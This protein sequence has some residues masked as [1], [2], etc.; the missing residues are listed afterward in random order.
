MPSAF[1]LARNVSAGKIRGLKTS[2]LLT[3]PKWSNV[4]A[5]AVLL[6]LATV[7]VY[8][9]ILLAY[10]AN[11][12]TLTVGYAPVQ[13]VPYSHAMH[14]GKLGMDCRY[15]HTTV[16]RAAFAALPP[17]DVCMNCHKAILP[18]SPKLGLVQESYVEGTPVP[19]VKVHLMAD[20]VYF[21]HSAH[22]NVGV[23]CIECHG[24][25]Q[26]METV[27]IVKPL[28]MAWCLECHRDPRPFLRPRDQ[29]TN[30]DWTPLGADDPRVR[31]DLGKRLMENYHVNPSTDCVTCHR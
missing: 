28:N 25:I 10:G 27:E 31:A 2:T 21:N 15:C 4:A 14:V 3:F 6:G 26:Q 12:T 8:L 11:P 20:Y 22:V 1:P 17:T 30:M 29:V 16:E 24:P 5:A 23:G 9:G 18:D 7:P 19:W 13:P